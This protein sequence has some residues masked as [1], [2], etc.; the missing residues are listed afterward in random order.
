MPTEFSSTAASPDSATAVLPL[1]YAQRPQSSSFRW[2]I[3]VLVFFAI[4][5]NYID[6]M[7]MGIL[8][9]DLADKLSINDN[10]YGWITFSFSISYALGQMVSGRWLDWIGTRV[11]YAV[12]LLGWSIASMLHAIVRTATGFGVMRGL[13]GVTESPAF[14]AATKTVAEW[15]PKKERAFAMGFVNAG[16]NVGAFLAPIAVPWLAVTYGWQ[17]AFVLTGLVGMVWL[18][19]WVPIYRRPHEHPRVSASELA[20]INSDVDEAPGKVRWR[21]LLTYN[22]AWAFGLGK[23]M[24]DPIWSFYLFWF[25]SFLHDRYGVSLIGFAA[26]MAVIYLMADGGSIAGGWLS[27]TMITRGYSINAARKTALLVCALCVLPSAF[28][29]VV[30]GMWSA[31]IIA[32]IALAAHQG[33]SSNLYTLV[34]DTFPRRAVGSVAGLGG[35][36]GYIGTALFMKLVGQVLTITHKNYLPIFIICASA[37]LIA[38]AIIHALMPRIAP[39][40]LEPSRGFDVQTSDDS[41]PR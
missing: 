33:F 34:S 9:P 11:G 30:G 32:G 1:E 27:S 7:V 36:F 41:A 20:H 13:L 25:T 21:K 18:I 8:K 14:P 26:P 6:R 17:S 4:T 19:F 10:A 40:A 23:F 39:V 35:T 29:S 28:A 37:Y 12:A 24:T 2:V 16:S 3:L 22:A 31:V 15:F 38:L 5:I